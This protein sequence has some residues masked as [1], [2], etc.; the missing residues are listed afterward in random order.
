MLLIDNHKITDPAINLALEEH[1]YRNLDTRHEYVL[2][3]INQPSIVIGNHQSPFQEI[4][5]ELAA[6]KQIRSIRR[7]SGGGAVY[8]DTG[9]LNFSFITEFGEEKLDYFK[10]LL[11]PVIDTLKRL[12]VPA[13]LSGKNNIVVENK[14]ISGNS[15]HANMRRMLSHGT[16]LFDAELDTLQQ[17]LQSNLEIIESRAIASIPSRVTNISDYLSRPM[18]M[19][20]FIAELIAG[21]SKSFGAVEGYQLATA[22]WDAVYRLAEEKYRSWEWNIGRSPEFSVKH[23]LQI[24][25]ADVEVHIQVKKAII[26]DIHIAGHQPDPKIINQNCGILIGQRYDPLHLR[27]LQ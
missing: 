8:H 13:G 20:A 1:C 11:Q 3:Y 22:D 14:K 21:V 7:I 4:N 10:Q 15:Q 2:F 17:V 23:K 27:L 26:E 19:E 9:N 6:Q 16:L 12:G 25:S 5:T 24:D 18:E